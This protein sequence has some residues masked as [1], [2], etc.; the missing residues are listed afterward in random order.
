LKQ[1]FQDVKKMQ[2]AQHIGL[3]FLEAFLHTLTAHHLHNTRVLP[4]IPNQKEKATKQ[5]DLKLRSDRTFTKLNTQ[6]HCHYMTDE[7]LHDLMAGLIH[8]HIKK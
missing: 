8:P 6:I 5:K 2:A 3:H 4:V 1:V 7:K